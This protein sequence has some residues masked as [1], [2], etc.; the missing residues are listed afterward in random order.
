MTA[1]EFAQLVSSF[2]NSARPGRNLYLWCGKAQKLSDMLGSLNVNFI[3]LLDLPGLQPVPS[4]EEAKSLIESS[5]ELW[6][7]GVVEINPQYSIAVIKD[8]ELQAFYGIGLEKV[9]LHHASDRRMTILCVEPPPKFRQTIPL[10]LDYS[11]SVVEQY[12]RRLF[13]PQNII[14]E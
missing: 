13:P 8:T 2:R 11:M 9:Y 10:P 1:R 6:L 7:K 14:E 5:L 12:Y 4:S 3:S